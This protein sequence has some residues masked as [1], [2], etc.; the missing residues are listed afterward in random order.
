MNYDNEKDFINIVENLDR[1]K[2]SSEIFADFV[3]FTF[4][5]LVKPLATTIEA[6]EQH[7][8]DYMQIVEKYPKETIRNEFVALFQILL[9]QLGSSYNDF[10]GSV[11]QKLEALNLGLDQYFTPPEISKLMISITMGDI[12]EI[13]KKKGYVTLSEPTCGS[14]GMILAT[15]EI[16]IGK[17]YNPQNQLWFQAVDL[18]KLCYQMTYIQTSLPPIPEGWVLEK[19]PPQDQGVQKLPPIPEGFVLEQP[20]QPPQNLASPAPDRPAL[21]EYGVNGLYGGFANVAGMPVDV[22]NWGLGKLGV[23]V[24]K[25]PFLGSNYNKDALSKV[26]L[27]RDL[28]PKTTSEKFANRIG[29][30]I[31]SAAIPAAG[32]V[33]FAGRGVAK[34]GT[35]VNSFVREG[36]GKVARNPKKFLVAEAGTATGAGIGA[37]TAKEIAPDSV[38]AEMAG[39]MIGGISPSVFSAGVRGT[40]RGG[41]AGRKVMQK[42]IEDF[43]SLNATPTLGQATNG[44][45]FKAI[46]SISS[47]APL[48]G[49]FRNHAEH[50]ARQIARRIEN[51]R[52]TKGELSAERAGLVIKRGI[53]GFKEEFNKKAGKLYHRLDLHIQ[54][55]SPVNIDKFKMVLGEL[56]TDIKGASSL[57]K[58]LNSNDLREIQEALFRDMGNTQT[59]PYQA[60][61]EIRSKIGKKLKLTNLTSDA[62]N[63][64]LKRLYGALTEDMG[65]AAYNKSPQAFRAFERANTY[66]SAGMTR[67]ND[68]LNRIY[69]KANPEDMFIA[70][71]KGKEGA[72]TIR[73][74]R[75]SMSADDWSVITDTVVKRL[76]KAKSSHQDDVGDIFS[77]E[78]FLTNWN[79]LAPEAKQALFNPETKHNLNKIAKVAASI[80]ENANVMRN[81]SGTTESLVNIS[82]G[83]GAAT[84]LGSGNML[85]LGGMA[86]TGAT[87]FIGSRL[88]PPHLILD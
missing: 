63:G 16:M 33:G 83:V 14:G 3:E 61:K 41:E 9:K 46:E 26:Y 12:D 75:R 4:S 52:N 57:S 38:I 45:V 53:K 24:S 20:E 48:G 67:I 8:Q 51:M 44:K 54:P 84:A 64:D 7:E 68:R 6:K 15:A 82:A 81:P 85:I 13:I 28:Q 87:N 31:G 40:F 77:S 17:G 69:K 23:P 76:G 55:E 21:W 35:A 29:E 71:T 43:E 88:L 11:A 70:A 32:I 62:S 50:T 30:E 73:A 72:S 56:N 5:A 2:R 42:N 60:L 79:N 36:L 66:Y 34:T 47:K 39:A 80:R 86:A 10:L 59:V 1:S 22:V 37:E 25:K 78:T 65:A 74:V 58:L 49:G 19:Q 18:S 27:Y